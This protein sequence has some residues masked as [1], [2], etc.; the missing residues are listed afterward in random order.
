M[1]IPDSAHGTNPAS[2]AM[3]GF[4]VVEVRSNGRGTIDIEHLSSLMDEDTAG[5]MITNPN[6]VG[7]FEEEI[8][9]ICKIIHDKGGL[10]S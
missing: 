4:E 2:S 8:L 7:L 6:T 9:S 10:G 1:I 3:A 5:I